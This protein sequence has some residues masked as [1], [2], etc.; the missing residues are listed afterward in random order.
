MSELGGRALYLSR[1]E[2]GLGKREVVE[3]VAR[4]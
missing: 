3:D 1:D 4:V 2:V